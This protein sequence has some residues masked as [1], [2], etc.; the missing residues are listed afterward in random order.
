MA[1]FGFY[2][3][4]IQ[5]SKLHS[6]IRWIVDILAV[7]ALAVFFV[8]EFGDT[9]AMVGRSMDP[10]LA[11]GDVVLLNRI[12]QDLVPL[13]RF[14]V[15]LFELP[16]GTG[17]TS[18]KRVVGLPGESV[19]IA[20]GELLIDGEAVESEH[21]AQPFTIGGVAEE[22]VTLGE[23]EFFVLGDNAGSS[24]D[25]RFAGVGNVRKEDIAGRVWF[26]I[27]PAEH[28]GFVR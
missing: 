2:R 20:G 24:E 21:T 4:N 17:R 27:S 13:E 7:A 14:D 5:E 25:S 15:I 11:S 26:C 22:T 3:D 10:T 1:K 23:D 19:Q 6:V 16:D 18:I 28:V 8:A 9:E 12:S